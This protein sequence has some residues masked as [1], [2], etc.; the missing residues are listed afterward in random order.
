[1]HKHLMR[2]LHATANIEDGAEIKPILRDCYSPIRKKKTLTTVRQ[3]RSSNSK[4]FPCSFLYFRQKAVATRL[5]V[6]QM[7]PISKLINGAS[8]KKK[9]MRLK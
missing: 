5:P 7:Y 2:L 9:T 1:M 4:D 3:S 8:R 6:F